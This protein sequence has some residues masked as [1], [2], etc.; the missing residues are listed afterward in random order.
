MGIPTQEDASLMISLFRLR[1]DPFMQESEEWFTS[2]FE[3]DSWEELKAKHHENSREWRM[4]T[5]VLG[6]WEMLGALVDHNLLSE[7]LLFDVMEG[8]DITWEKV[9]NW[10]PSARSEMGPDLWEN[11]ELLATRQQKWRFTRLPKAQRV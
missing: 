10:V 9:R 1:L 6:Y 11:I 8:M 3:P 5:T 7:D 4:L 2:H